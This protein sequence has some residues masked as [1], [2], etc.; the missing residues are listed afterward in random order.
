M[1]SSLKGGALLRICL[2]SIF[3]NYNFTKGI[4]YMSVKIRLSLIGKKHVP[5]FRI[6][7]VDS[8]KK[9]DGRFLAM[10]GTYNVLKG[11]LVEFNETRYNEWIAKGALP[12]NSAKKIFK[13]YKKSVA[14]A[15][16]QQKKVTEQ[17]KITEKVKEVETQKLPSEKSKTESLALPTTKSEVKE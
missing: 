9:R 8:R 16:K 17:K 15:E 2:D 4:I 1:L 5:F 6:V 13:Q 14:Q 11:E 10:M 12:T 3:I 7:A